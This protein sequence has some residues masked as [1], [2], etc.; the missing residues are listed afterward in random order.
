MAVARH[1][2][3]NSVKVLREGAFPILEKEIIAR[4]LK[5]E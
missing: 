3:D 5:E 2:A 1:M 4:M